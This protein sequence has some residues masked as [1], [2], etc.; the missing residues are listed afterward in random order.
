V[1]ELVVLVYLGGVGLTSKPRQSF[2]E[3]IYLHGF[4]AGNQ[5]VN[6]QI[7]LVPIDQQGVSY[8]PTDHTGIVHIHII[9]IVHD[10]DALAL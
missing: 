2:L 10:V 6:P 8:V 9:N 4:V 3:D 7:E 5:H 1:H